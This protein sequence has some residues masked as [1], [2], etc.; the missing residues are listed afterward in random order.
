[1]GGF[2]IDAT[3]EQIDE[4]RK[5]ISDYA[6]QTANRGQF[7]E[8]LSTAK[9]ALYKQPG[10]ATIY[11]RERGLGPGIAQNRLEKR[12]VDV[13]GLVAN[14]PTDS[15]YKKGGKVKKKSSVKSKKNIN[16]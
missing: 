15:D 16:W 14:V 6:Q 11:S 5:K 10:D 12:G 3:P 13:P 7:N 4:Q 8:D 1:M 2:S 9:R